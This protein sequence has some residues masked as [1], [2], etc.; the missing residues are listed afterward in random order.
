MAP[1]IFDLLT[2]RRAFVWALLGLLVAAGAV[3]TVR[4]PIDMSFRPT[5]STDRTEVQRTAAHEKIFGQVGFRDLVAIVDA[6]GA[7]PPSFMTALAQLAGRLRAMPFVVEVRD[8]T[9]FPFFD[10]DGSLQANGIAGALPAGATFESSSARPLIEDLLRSPSA[11]RVVVGDPVGDR[12]GDLVGDNGWTF[13]VTASLD[14]PNESFARRRAAVAAFERIVRDWSRETGLPAQITGYPEVEQVYAVE[15]LRSVLQ[16]IAILLLVMVAVLFVYFRRW[17]DV[18]TCLCG[19]SLSVPIVL[20]TMAAIGQPFSIVNSQVLTLVLIVG[21][22]QA[23]HQQE[24]YRR[25]REAGRDHVAANREAFSILAW[26]SFMTGLATAA[27]FGA[28]LTADMRAIWSF[29]L[30]TA[31]GVCIVYVVNWAVGP[32]LIDLFYRGAPAES[33]LGTRSSG[34]LAA[35][36][37]ADRL[38]RRHPA[39]VTLAFLAVTIALGV[40]GVSRLSV[41]QKVNEELTADHPALRAERAYESQL[42]GFLGPELSVRPTAAGASMRDLTGELVRFVDRLCDMPEVRYV[43]SPLDLMPQPLLPSGQRGKACKRGGGEMGFATGARRGLAGP[44]VAAL[45]R[46]VLSEEGTGAAIIVRVA[47][48]GTARSLPF[49]EQIRAAARETMPHATVEPVGQ[50][51]LAQQGMNRLS[52]DVMLSAV[53]ALLVILPIM[54]F[55]IR[56]WKLFL[57]AIPPTVLPIAATLGFMGLAHITVRIGTAMILAIALG[58]AADDTVHLSVRIRDRVRRGSEVGSAISATLLR[59]GRPCSFSSYVLIAGFGSMLASSLLALR[60]MGEIAMFTMAFALATDVVLG[61]AIYLLLFR[62]W[63][64]T[65]SAVGSGETLRDLFLRTLERHPER[66]ALTYA[67]AEASPP[68]SARGRR[69]WRTLSWNEV[70]HLVVEV[71]RALA[72]R[73][74]EAGTGAATVAFTV[75][76]LADTDPRYF[77]L[78]LAV[79][80]VG[81]AVQP[82]YVSSTD[83]EL[84]RALA[85]TGADLLV[86]GRSQQAR[87]AVLHPRSIALEEIVRLPGIDTRSAVLP[88]AVEPFDVSA[89]R[90]A[91]AALPARAPE[92]ALLFLQS[93]GTTGPARVIEISERALVAAVQAVAGEASHEFPRF[94]SF[95]PT[96]HISERLLTLYLSIALVGHTYFGGGLAS[97]VDDLRACHP[98]V[99]LAPPLLL[100]SIQSESTRAASA[101]AVGRRLLASVRRTAEAIVARG[102]GGESARGGGARFFGWQLRRQLGLDRVLDA[103]S[104]TAPLSM[105]LGAWFE[106]VG[107]PVRNVYGQTEL[108]GATSMTAR[109]G[110][111]IGTQIGSVGRPVRGVEVRISDGQELLVRSRSAFTR[112]VGDESATART[113]V[114]G[115]LHSGDR[116]EIRETGD[117]VLAGRVQPV[118]IATDGA[119]VDTAAMASRL[120]AAL[121]DAEVVLSPLDDRGEVCLYVARCSGPSG[122]SGASAPLEDGDPLWRRISALVNE[123][124]PQGVIRGWALFE[125][126]FTQVTGEVGPTGKPRGWRIHELRSNHL[127]SRSGTAGGESPPG[128]RRCASA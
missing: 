8:P 91:I 5:F 128:S 38:L 93:T 123:V 26:P 114:D 69:N 22:G 54:W 78:E 15:V 101:S 90:A 86:V 12:A 106:A 57:A 16:G 60:A 47:D 103:L 113:L 53:T 116:A 56:D 83:D 87:G 65:R 115:W 55:G 3:G 84:R 13:A 14:I 72:E 105:S 74:P 108:T 17:S 117:I 68:S 64:Q 36:R 20:G 44:S 79:G 7:R 30:S 104:G 19:V 29:G 127:R 33:F 43:A 62:R 100:E 48:L 119:A 9:R 124:D 4:M 81:G 88:A 50:W 110:S 107:L 61:P 39:G 35:I 18:V 24:E 76:I 59:T 46:S 111:Q 80:L 122:P 40:A 28:L 98:T 112:Y 41:D 66:P 73:A 77:L 109:R 71:A 126:G 94:L 58:L 102:V 27:G 45:A 51:W 70:A 89:A 67:S 10:R 120:K 37:W 82:L 31:L 21:I 125:D 85:A 6:R 23:L 96:A 34:T 121:G 25:R 97:V 49:V 75:A 99:F 11:R 32:A 52:R 118:V 1:R 2:R 63:G 42:A 92:A 95:L